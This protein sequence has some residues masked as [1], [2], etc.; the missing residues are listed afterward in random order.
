[1]GH[2]RDRSGLRGGW[3]HAFLQRRWQRRRRGGRAEAARPPP[4]V[5]PAFLPRSILNLRPAPAAAATPGTVLGN[6]RGA[7]RSIPRPAPF[8]PPAA[9]PAPLPH[10]LRPRP[11]RPPTAAPAP[12]P[13]TPHPALRP[14]HTSARPTRA[15]RSAAP[16]TTQSPPRARSSH[17]HSSAGRAWGRA[18]TLGAHVPRG[19]GNVVEGEPGGGRPAQAPSPAGGLPLLAGLRGAAVGAVLLAE[20]H[21]GRAAGGGGRDGQGSG[22]G[23]CRARRRSAA[24]R[25]R[26][27]GQAPHVPR[28]GGSAPPARPLA[29]GG[30]GAPGRH[31]ARPAPGLVSAREAGP[32]P[33]PG[34]RERG[35]ECDFEAPTEDLSAS[36]TGG[37]SPRKD[38]LVIVYLATCA[39]P[40]HRDRRNPPGLSA[41]TPRPALPKAASGRGDR[42]R[43]VPAGPILKSFGG[44]CVHLTP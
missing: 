14:A 37:T 11:P 4:R 36:R 22:R 24:A 20:R 3:T 30:A 6:A 5:G 34:A 19:H 2:R 9:A 28:A 23:P 42:C 39:P 17:G 38:A 7:R 26:R 29:G 32:G 31:P 40:V 35:P 33:P 44:S 13:P 10:G 43:D 21:G 27:L 1:M 12:G 15:L 25:C 16:P 41:V 18:G 8:N